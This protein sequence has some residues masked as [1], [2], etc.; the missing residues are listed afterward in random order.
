MGKYSGARKQITTV[1][2]GTL[3]QKAGEGSLMYV[4]A[5]VHPSQRLSAHRRRF[6]GM[7]EMLVTPV[8]NMRQVE[9]QLLQF[10]ATTRVENIQH[11][12]NAR[13][14]PGY[15]YGITRD[16]A[17]ARNNAHEDVAVVIFIL[18]FLMICALVIGLVWGVVYTVYFII[19]RIKS[20]LQQRQGE[21]KIKL[22]PTE[23]DLLR[24]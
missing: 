20:K 7:G 23:A 18:I 1:P 10:A 21:V 6:V 22:Q 17:N 2:I 8:A 9:D 12:S 16:N 11:K 14:L 4:G 15:V 3:L 13:D 19:V 24:E 5:T